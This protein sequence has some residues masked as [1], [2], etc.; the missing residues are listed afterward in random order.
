MAGYSRV[1]TSNNIADGNVISAADL[2]GEFDGVQS[3]FNSTTGH[4]HG[5]DTGEGAPIVKIGPSND[6][7]AS[8]TLLA[9]KTTATVSLGSTGL[10]FKDLH[11]SGD[12]T[13]AGI[14]AAILTNSTGLPIVNGTTGTLSVAR[15][16]TGSTTLT[17]NNVLLGN[18]T[19]ALQAVAPGTTGNVLTSDGTTWQSSAPIAQVYPSAGI[20]VSTGTAWGTSKTTPAGDV[21]GTSDTQTLSNKSVSLSDNT[22]SGT[23]AQFNTALTDGDFAT[24]NGTET[25]SNKTINGLVLNDGYTEEVFAVTGTTPALSPTSGSIQTWTLTA[26]STPTAGTWAAGQSIT[27]MID[28]GTAYTITWTSLA[29]TWKTDGGLAP[30][31]NTTGFTA[32]V[33]W[34]VGTTIYGARV[35]NA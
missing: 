22:I 21:V 16:G 11:L 35:G 19:S 14:V 33:L 9:P 12:A 30:T 5:G 27:L 15:G 28:D 32:I 26:N 7:T 4:T 1:D 31:L 29:V 20:A 24:I 25:L 10:K 23:T 17:A 18:G 3:A 8:A 6:V 13:I 34:K 2:D